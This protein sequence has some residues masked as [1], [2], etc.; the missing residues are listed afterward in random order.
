MIDQCHTLCKMGIKASAIDYNCLNA[1]TFMKASESDSESDEDVDVGDISSEPI[2]ST[3]CLEDTG[4]GEYQVVYAHPEALLQ[5]KREERL[6][7]KLSHNNRLASLAI[8]EAHM[9]LEL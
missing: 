6:L 8:D 7:N 2:S 4:N 9:I 3:V 5:T 1:E